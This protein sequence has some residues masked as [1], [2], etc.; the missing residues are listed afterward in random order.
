MLLARAELRTNVVRDL[1]IDHGEIVEIAPRLCPLADEDV[2]DVGGCAVIPG[3]H[4]HHVHLRAAAAASGSLDLA[5]VRDANTLRLALRRAA[6]EL[7]QGAWL[8]AIGY[9]ESIAGVLDRA[10]LDEL[11][12]TDRPVRVQHRSGALWMLNSVAMDEMRLDC[13]EARGVNRSAGHLW[14]RDDLVRKV[15]TLDPEQLTR[16]GRSAAAVGVTGFTDATPG[17]GRTHPLDLARELRDAGAKQNLLLMGPVGATSPDTER[18]SL[19][20]VKILLDDDRLP[21]LAELTD[22]IRAA[23]DDHRP[24]AIHC[25]TRVQLVLATTA[26][27]EVGA[28][29]SDRIEHGSVIPTELIGVLARLGVTVVTQPH[30]VA[31]RGDDYQR[32]VDP[33]DLGSMYRIR[34]LLDAGIPVAAGTDAPFGSADPWPSI[35][36]AVERRT[37][38]G[39]PLGLD[40][41]VDP[42]AAIGLYLGRPEAPG[43]ARTV[44]VGRTADL[45]VLGTPWRAV[46]AGPPEG[47]VRYTFITGELVHPLD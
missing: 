18:A 16:L 43:V 42:E 19:G 36:A 13:S 6:T 10:A 22:T 29:R 27:G 30:F 17:G 7:P 35:R 26:L 32:D 20:P 2:L 11:I 9:H 4:D 5:S 46:I 12:P 25:V 41:A 40:E 1:R 14:R 38:T 44:E 47:Q 31:E 37:P 21:L 24:V 8:R 28:H 34:S 33:G 15:S 45:C 23:H 39:M 3:L